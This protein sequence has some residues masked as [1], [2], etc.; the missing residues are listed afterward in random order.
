L[1][2]DDTQRLDYLALIEAELALVNN[3]PSITAQVYC[4]L[5]I[6]YFKAKNAF[7]DWHEVEDDCA[8]VLSRYFHGEQFERKPIANHEHYTRASELLSCS[9]ISHGQLTSCRNSRN[10]RRKSFAA[11]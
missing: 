4:V 3:R 1:L 10:R 7:F 6:G 5:Q 11:M 2:I 9:A 8:F